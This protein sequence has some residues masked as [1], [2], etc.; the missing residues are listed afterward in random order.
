M[1]EN[2]KQLVCLFYHSLSSF[3]RSFDIY[4]VFMEIHFSS[5]AGKY[6]LSSRPKLEFS[7]LMKSRSRE[8]ENSSLTSRWSYFLVLLW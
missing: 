1:D 5:K 4:F 7:R 8:V 3:E 6:N 2:R